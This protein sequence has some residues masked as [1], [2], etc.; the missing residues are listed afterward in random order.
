MDVNK[1]IIIDFIK[2][3]WFVLWFF[4][5]IECLFNDKIYYKEGLWWEDSKNDV[6]SLYDCVDNF[7]NYVNIFGLWKWNNGYRNCFVKYIILCL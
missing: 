2:L 5:F 7:N 4:D 6:V 3:V 1:R